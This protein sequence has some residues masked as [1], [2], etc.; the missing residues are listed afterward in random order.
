MKFSDVV[1]AL[2]PMFVLR[3]TNVKDVCAYLAKNGVI[4]NTWGGGNRKPVDGTI[5]K[6]R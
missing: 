2:L 3:E 1:D 5:I 4:E 6:R